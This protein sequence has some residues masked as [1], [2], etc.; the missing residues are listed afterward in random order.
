MHVVVMQNKEMAPIHIL[1]VIASLI[2][3]TLAE[4]EPRG[5]SMKLKTRVDGAALCA[6]DDPS[7]RAGMSQR[8]SGAPE[9][10]RCGMTCT[11]NAQC[12][13]FNYVS[14]EPNPCELYYNTPTHFDVR[15]NCQHYYQPGE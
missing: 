5:Q 11:S 4:S 2:T 7:L 15:P 6:T 8:M 10:V 3:M 14:T 13:H 1:A 9:A 12:K